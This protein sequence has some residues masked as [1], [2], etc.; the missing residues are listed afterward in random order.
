MLLLLLV[1]WDYL[2][3]ECLPLVVHMSDTIWITLHNTCI[4]IAA[5]GVLRVVIAVPVQCLGFESE[6]LFNALIQ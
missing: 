3:I 1:L 5:A 6:L 4:P 2:V